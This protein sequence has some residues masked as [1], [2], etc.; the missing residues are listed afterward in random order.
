MEDQEK[1][2]I[3]NLIAAAEG[4]RKQKDF[5]VRRLKTALAA[6]RARVLG[7]GGG[8]EERKQS[9]GGRYSEEQRAHSAGHACT[10]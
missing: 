4:A 2:E 7:E 5:F 6:H 8:G 9:D 10:P 1:N 3:K